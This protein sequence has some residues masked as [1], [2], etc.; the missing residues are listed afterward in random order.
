[1]SRRLQGILFDLGDTILNFGKVDVHMLFE[2][3]ARRAHDY[4]KEIGQP[5][6]SLARFHRRQFWAIRWSYFISHFTRREFNSLDLMTQISHKMGQDLTREQAEELAWKWYEPLSEHA[7]VEPGTRDMMQAILEKGLTVG[8]VSNTFLPG[9]VLDRHLAQENLLEFFPLR[10]Y[11]CDVGYRKPSR[12]I[13]RKAL[14]EAKL[15]AGCTFFVGDSLR[16]DV[17][18]SFRA[19]MIPVWKASTDRDMAPPAHARHVITELTQLNDLVEE[20]LPG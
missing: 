4:L 10:V 3:G 7:T 2:A 6:P 20:Y 1:M 11:S 15:D 16:A 5:V 14:R 18:G 9:S 19:G 13:F 17:E 12:R 8:I